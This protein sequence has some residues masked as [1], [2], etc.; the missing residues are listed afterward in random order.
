MDYKKA[1][2]IE[3][4][5]TMLREAGDSVLILAGGTDVMAGMNGK[6]ASDKT[7]IYIG[8]IADLRG[9]RETP[10]DIRIGSLVTAAEIEESEIIARYAG[11]LCEAAKE[12]ASPQVR[13]RATIGGNIATASPAGDLLCALFAL[14]ASIVV[15]TGGD[16]RKIS[17]IITG[18]KKTSLKPGELITEIIIPKLS[19]ICGSDF[20]KVGKRKA[21]SISITNVACAVSLGRGGRVDEIRIAIGASAPTV[22]RAA[23]MENALKGNIVNESYIKEK[24]TLAVDAIDPITDQ[25]ATMWYRREVIPVLAARAVTAAVN[26]AESIQE[27]AK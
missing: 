14:D 12:S 16:V 18:A 5:L 1:C 10:G 7:V 4:A 9:I 3:D 13:N 22:V 8:D 17:D 24:S 6:P 25:R 11:A 21:M 15:G 19:G 2:N 27:V 26:A 20:L 23:A